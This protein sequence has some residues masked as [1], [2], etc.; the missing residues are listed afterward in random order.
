MFSF[1][2]IKASSS[3]LTPINVVPMTITESGVYVIDDD[4]SYSGVDTAIKI[5]TSDVILIGTGSSLILTT[6][7][8]KGI[9]AENVHSISLIGLDIRMPKTSEYIKSIG[10]CLNGCS[11]VTIESSSIWGTAFGIATLHSSNVTLN[12][13]STR[14]NAIANLLFLSTK[15][16]DCSHG[17][18]S[19]ENHK[20]MF[21]SISFDKVTD[22]RM[23]SYSLLNADIY[24]EEGTNLLLEKVESSIEDPQYP[25]GNLLIGSI[26][27]VRNVIIRE[28]SFSR[29]NLKATT[30]YNLGIIKANGVKVT[31]CLFDLVYTGN[32][33]TNATTNINLGCYNNSVSGVEHFSMKDSILRGNTHLGIQIGTP[34]E[35]TFNSTIKLENNEISGGSVCVCNTRNLLIKSNRVMMSGNNG[36]ELITKVFSSIITDNILTD[37]FGNGIMMGKDVSGNFVSN[38]RL[39]SNGGCIQ[40][41]EN[42]TCVDNVDIN[43]YP[44]GTGERIVPTVKTCSFRRSCIPEF[45]SS[46]S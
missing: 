46:L 6:T 9:L 19:N 14:N 8:A 13:V 17:F 24:L 27:I 10:I 1:S 12:R 45:M 36:I 41:N 16:V 43:N 34:N 29:S 28:C 31:E 3:R 44:K 33:E 4:L 32:K 25:D 11:D 15:G 20:F 22:A 26:G 5:T 37:H 38:N 2:W 39:L 40:M 21:A 18:V 35:S 42:N 7:S 23:V 30:G